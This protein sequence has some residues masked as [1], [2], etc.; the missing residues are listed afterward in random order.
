[1]DE[2]QKVKMN[3]EM[4]VDQLNQIRG[5]QIMRR[6]ALKDEPVGESEVEEREDKIP[7]R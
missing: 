7:P 6:Q 2:K 1:M 5:R 4:I 3:D